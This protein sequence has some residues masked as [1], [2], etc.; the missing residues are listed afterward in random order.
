[1]KKR[2]KAQ[3]ENGVGYACLTAPCYITGTNFGQVAF[4][5]FPEVTVAIRP[6]PAGRGGV[7]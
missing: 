7:R 5:M 4:V 2:K 1:M 3:D 6:L